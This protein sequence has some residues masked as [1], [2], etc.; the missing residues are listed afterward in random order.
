[1]KTKNI[2]KFILDFIED[3]KDSNLDD[4]KNKLESKNTQN[5][6]KKLLNKNIKTVKDFNK[7]KRGK[8]SYLYF[9]EDNRDKVKEDFPGYDNKKIVTELG[10][11]WNKFK[12]E[13]P[14]QVGEYE[15]R[16]SVAREIYLK[17]IKEYNDSKKNM[18]P[19]E[20]E[21]DETKKEKKPKK[22]K[23]E[24][25]KDDIKKDDIKKDDIKKDDIKEVVKEKKEKNPKKIEESEVKKDNKS[26][27]VE[28]EVKEEVIKKEKKDKK[29]KD[30]EVVLKDEKSEQK[31]IEKDDEPG[32]ET[33]CKKKKNKFTEENSDMSEKEILKLMKK[34]WKN[35]SADKKQKYI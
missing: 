9:C 4:L 27:E 17:D 10:I 23:V 15:K 8:S 20:N 16:A 11:R 14:D 12:E 25:K 32:F 6:L 19:I 18:K 29:K 31:S 24:V 21:K 3:N 2:S 34:K 1:M 26:A 33:F 35:L 13:H 28:E 5:D 30:K 22:E 7:P